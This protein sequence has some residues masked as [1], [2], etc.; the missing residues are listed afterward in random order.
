VRS[1][2]KTLMRLSALGTGALGLMAVVFITA[3]ALVLPFLVGL[4]ALAN[5]SGPYALE[6][7]AAIDTSVGAVERALA[8]KDW[9]AAQENA[10]RAIT[11][12][13]QLE[14]AAGALPRLIGPRENPSVPDVRTQLQLAIECMQEAEQAARE[15]DAER[16]KAAV[17]KFH[18]HYGPI[19]KAAPKAPK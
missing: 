15:K 12:T 3:V 9:G 8:D 6:Q 19:A 16:L 7:I 11:A 10:R 5:I 2:N 18:E 4:P 1:E 14:W 13:N 17:R